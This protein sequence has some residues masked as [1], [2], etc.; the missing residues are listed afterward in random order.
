MA[1]ARNKAKYKLPK[2]G[3]L[4]VADFLRVIEAIGEAVGYGVQF[5]GARG[6]SE[7]A[8]GSFK[9]DFNKPGPRGAEGPS[10]ETGSPGPNGDPGLAP[11]GN[12]GPDGYPGDPGDIGDTPALPGPPGPKG[13]DGDPGN[14]KPGPP[15]T[16]PG[17]PGPDGTEEGPKGPDGDPG[18]NQPGPLG[19]PGPKGS[20]GPHGF[21]IPGEPGDP[22]EPGVPGDKFAIVTLPDGRNVG[23]HATEAGRPW[24]LDEITFVLESSKPICPVFLGTIEPDSVRVIQVSRQGI[25][26]KI[27]RGRIILEGAMTSSPIVVTIAGIRR[28]FSGWHFKQFSDAQRE[29]NERFYTSA[30]A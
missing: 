21:Y 19:V 9:V 16:D 13:F 18:D 6:V 29:R 30:Y 5:N 3:F 1:T 23:Y 24:F 15:G 25:G 12:P 14:D 26:A 4:R 11:I 28:G 22:G 7:N 2:P 27:E 10:G 17:D 8:D 20:K